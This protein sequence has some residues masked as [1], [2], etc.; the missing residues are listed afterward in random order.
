MNIRN[1]NAFGLVEVI[2]SIMIISCVTI[3]GF[4]VY[5]LMNRYGER[6]EAKIT[7]FNLANSQIEDLTAIARKSL[8][9]SLLDITTHTTQTPNLDPLNPAGSGF[10]ITYTVTGGDWTEDGVTDT[11]FKQITVTCTYGSGNSA[12]LI[13]FVS[14]GSR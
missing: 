13:G 12:V 4:A 7:A 3:S 6:E 8:N 9:D 5:S 11:D 10:D 2:T 1:K 14:R